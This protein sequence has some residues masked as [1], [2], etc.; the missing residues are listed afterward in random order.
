[1]PASFASEEA[2]GWTKITFNNSETKTF[3]SVKNMHSSPSLSL[4]WGFWKVK[5]GTDITKK[6][7]EENKDTSDLKISFSMTQT[8][9]MRNWFAPEF[10]L[11]KGWRLKDGT[12]GPIIADGKGGGPLSAY[13]TT[14]IWIKDVKITSK[15][16]ADHVKDNYLKT[17][18]D[19]SVGWGPFSIGGR[20]TT[21]KTEKTQSVSID[22]NTVTIKGYQIIAFMCYKM[23]LAPD[24]EI[25]DGDIWV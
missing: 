2:E 21:E 24:P 13:P 6:D 18:T 25:K 10:L 3:S 14:A 4:G 8:P 20:T 22:G 15:A 12:L 9:I 23:P 1:V 19:A 16:F 17:D 7:V 5:A 11:S